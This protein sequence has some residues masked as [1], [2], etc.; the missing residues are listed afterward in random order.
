MPEAAIVGIDVSDTALET[1]K[2]NVSA[3]SLSNVSLRHCDILTEDPTSEGFDLIVSNPPYIAEAEHAT[4]APELRLFEPRIALTDEAD[5][6]SF[7]RRIATL[8]AGTL[9]RHG[10]LLLELG[11]GQAAEVTEI[12]H[13][14]GLTVDW[15]TEDLSGIPR[16][17][18]AA[19]PKP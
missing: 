11:H 15:I 19:R 8:A 10:A 3:L 4:L 2:R 13:T 14:A 9:P 16:V 12:I 18:V 1:A 7:Y 17:L 5:G 6:L